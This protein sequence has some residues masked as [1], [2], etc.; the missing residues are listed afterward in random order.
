M[1]GVKTCGIQICRGNWCRWMGEQA[2]NLG[3]QVFA[4]CSESEIL[5]EE[6]GGG[7]GVESGEMGREKAGNEKDEAEAGDEGQG[8]YTGGVEHSTVH[9]I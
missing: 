2:E 7:S 8:G 9:S 5:D 3:V 6:G 4:G 1:T